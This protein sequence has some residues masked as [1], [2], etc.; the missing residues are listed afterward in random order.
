M[1]WRVTKGIELCS[2]TSEGS[3]LFKR[4]RCSEKYNNK[5]DIKMEW[6]MWS[7]TSIK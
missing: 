2:K 6:A 3:D 4:H 5:L 7:W 1:H